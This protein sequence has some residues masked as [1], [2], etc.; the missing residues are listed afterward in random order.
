MPAVNYAL[1][2]ACLGVAIGFGE[3]SSLAGAYGIAVTGT[4]IITS[5]FYLIVITRVWRWSLWLAVPL[6]TVFLV[7]IYI[8]LRGQSPQGQGRRLVYPACGR[9]LNDRHD[10]MEKRTF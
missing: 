1:M 8:L 5:I 4:M 3:S 9:A 10:H 6:V 2:V 7:F